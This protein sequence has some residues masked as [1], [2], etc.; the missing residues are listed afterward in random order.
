[1]ASDL[2]VPL[3]DIASDLS[4]LPADT[5]YLVPSVVACERVLFASIDDLEGS[6]DP[7]YAIPLNDLRRK[8]DRWRILLAAK[9][10][11]EGSRPALD[12]LA[13]ALKRAR[14]L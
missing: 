3:G 2:Q 7:G 13:E 11:R 6:E 12:M 5:V 14:R 1:V 8:P 4:G 10:T 9:K